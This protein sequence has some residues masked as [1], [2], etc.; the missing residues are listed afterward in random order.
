[1]L[2]EPFS[3]EREDMAFF[4]AISI[5]TELSSHES[6]IL[7]HLHHARFITS[8]ELDDESDEEDGLSKVPSTNAILYVLS[9]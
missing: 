8:E 2:T 9:S 3:C 6:T 7:L 1:M 5:E 4:K